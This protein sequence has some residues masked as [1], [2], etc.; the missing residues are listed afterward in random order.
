MTTIITN[1]A[2]FRKLPADIMRE[3]IMPYTHRPQ[4]TRLTQDIRSYYTDIWLLYSYYMVFAESPVIYCRR[5]FYNLIEFCNNEP[6][7]YSISYKYVDIIR[8]HVVFSGKSDAFIVNYIMSNFHINPSVRKIN[9]LVGLLTP[10]ERNDF[11][12]AFIISQE[13]S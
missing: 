13:P 7:T 8:R 1:P 12:N 3:H 10:I 5:L 11:I 2:L 4:S 6:P 9:F